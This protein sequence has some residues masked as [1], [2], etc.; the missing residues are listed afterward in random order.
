M[1]TCTTSMTKDTFSAFYRRLSGNTSLMKTLVDM[2]SGVSERKAY[3]IADAIVRDVAA[4][5]G[6]LEC[7]REDTMAVIDSFLAESEVL[8]GE[9]RMLNL[10]RLHFGLKV[11]AD[12]GL[13][14]AVKEGTGSGELFQRYYDAC[15]ND[16]AITEET[17][18]D[19][20]R[21][22]LASLA[23]SPE[24]M[25][26]IAKKL[27][28]NPTGM[29]ATAVSMGADGQRFKCILAMQL[30][31]ANKDKGM[32]TAEAASLACASAETQAI[33]DAAGRGLITQDQVATLISTIGAVIVLFSCFTW[34]G[35]YI[36][37][38]ATHSA[39]SAAVIKGASDTVL[40]GYLVALVS[41]A[42]G[43]LAGKLAAGYHFTHA[44]EHAEMMAGLHRMADTLKNRV[45]GLKKTVTEKVTRTASVS[46]AVADELADEETDPAFAF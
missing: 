32:T 34:L 7:L 29:L 28:E 44:A 18:T 23:V 20:I 26:A 24:V 15:K 31:T 6:T 1:T 30:Y 33:A 9:D 4:F 22:Q 16:P 17:L 42:C 25:T 21:Q 37:F 11:Y 43:K 13:V 36:S 39:A 38:W 35:G 27:E 3:E 14:E 19:A 41:D 2:Q 40:V 10:H 8:Q 12:A 5:E 46:D 45:S